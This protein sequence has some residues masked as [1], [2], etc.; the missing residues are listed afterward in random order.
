MFCE[1]AELVVQNVVEASLDDFLIRVFLHAELLIKLHDLEVLLI[2]AASLICLL[3]QMGFGQ[4]F[5]SVEVYLQVR[6]FQGACK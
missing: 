4:P 5:D 2:V 3:F 6:L 1:L